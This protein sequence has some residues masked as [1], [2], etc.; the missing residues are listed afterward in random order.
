MQQ[1]EKFVTFEVV[2]DSEFECGA[3]RASQVRTITLEINRG[4]LEGFYQVCPRLFVR[5]N[6]CTP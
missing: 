2:Y 5:N 4:W 6:I 3:Q 1:C